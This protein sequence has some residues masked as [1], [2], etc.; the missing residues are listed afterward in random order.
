MFQSTAE[1]KA[2]RAGERAVAP[3]DTH[4]VLIF[5]RVTGDYVGDFACNVS[6]IDLALFTEEEQGILRLMCQSGRSD[7]LEEMLSDDSNWIH[8]GVVT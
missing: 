7:V 3:I 6:V 2:R 4:P 8:K 5:D 1:D